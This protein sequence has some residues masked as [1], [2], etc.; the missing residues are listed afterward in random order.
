MSVTNL[1]RAVTRVGTVRPYQKENA[2]ARVMAYGAAVA[3]E[4]D[5]LADKLDRQWQW[6]ET[7]PGHP[8]TAER[9]DEWIATLR[10]Y[11]KACDALNAAAKAVLS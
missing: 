9:E 11:E 4:R 2:I 3:E 8:K 7:H 1:K 6:F 10:E 5:Q